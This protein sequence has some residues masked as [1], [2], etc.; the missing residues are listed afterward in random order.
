[1][2]AELKQKW[3]EAL[4]SGQYKQCTEFLRRD[5]GHCAIGVLCDVSGEVRFDPPRPDQTNP[6][7]YTATGPESGAAEYA[8]QL[9][10]GDD[11]YSA[12][13][14]MNDQD[15]LSFALIADWIETNIPAESDSTGASES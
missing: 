3:I 9:I 7:V 13:I 15:N 14:A 5:D 12:I 11:N 10:G 2:K 8:C 6:G 1:M 4:R